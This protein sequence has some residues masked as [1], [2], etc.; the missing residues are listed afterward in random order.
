MGFEVRVLRATVEPP[1]ETP[2]MVVIGLCR[3]I[4][5]PVEYLLSI[6]GAPLFIY[7]GMKVRRRLESAE[8]S[9][10]NHS[11]QTVVLICEVGVLWQIDYDAIVTHHETRG[12][13]TTPYLYSTSRP[14]P[15]GSDPVSYM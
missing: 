15:N 1:P 11:S 13:D 3:E 7:V 10:P 6:S 14:C 2:L 4:Y 8:Y 9:T 5:R 12:C